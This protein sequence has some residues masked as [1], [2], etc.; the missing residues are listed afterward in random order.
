MGK[1]HGPMLSPGCHLH[2]FSPEG[3]SP[4]EYRERA[5]QPE[6]RTTLNSCNVPPRVLVTPCID[7]VGTE[8]LTAAAW[9][10]VGKHVVEEAELEK[11]PT[12]L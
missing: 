6:Y 1:T 2:I 8:L 9:A 12:W 4:R 3:L 11:R 5:R 7:Y 10:L